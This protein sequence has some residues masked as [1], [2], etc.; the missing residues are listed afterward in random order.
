MT[1]MHGFDI[2]LPA[3]VT[4]LLISL[5][6]VPM[7]MEVLKRGIIFIDLAVAQAAALGV[8]VA[9]T[10]FH[11]AD[12]FLT[13]VFAFSAALFSSLIFWLCGK[14][15]KSYQEPMIGAAFVGFASLGL[16]IVSGNPHGTED[17]EAL[18]SGQILW[19]NW[20]DLYLPAILY[21]GLTALWYVFPKKST[22]FYIIFPL[23]ITVSVQL[24]GVY[25]VFATLVL[26]AL[27]V[28]N[29]KHPFLK[30]YL[31]SAISLILG[32]WISLIFDWPSG[33]TLVCIYIFISA[34]FSI[35]K[36][37]ADC[38]EERQKPSKL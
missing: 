30:A 9:N 27:G 11:D 3:L 18:L 34:L 7:G 13:T 6:H 22:L 17:I 12:L 35:S 4:G 20:N 8:I 38:K 28:V 21:L 1:A 14:I 24:I 25:L 10:V 32:L 33:P 19:V 31:L 36:A 15:A 37:C 23:A 16:I 29:Q 26:P 2:L 5:L